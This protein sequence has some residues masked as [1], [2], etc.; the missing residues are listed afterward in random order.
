VVTGQDSLAIEKAFMKA[1]KNHWEL[2]EN[3]DRKRISKKDH[4]S[5]LPYRTGFTPHPRIT[6][7]GKAYTC[8]I[9]RRKNRREGREAVV[10]AGLVTGWGEAIRTT[11]LKAW[12]RRG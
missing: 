7:I 4:A 6:K 12:A 1:E 5:L 2:K 10:I 9:E 3:K 8:H 11:A